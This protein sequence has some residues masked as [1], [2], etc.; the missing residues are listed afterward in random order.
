MNALWMLTNGTPVLV[1]VFAS[2]VL[3]QLQYHLSMPLSLSRRQRRFSRPAVN[4]AGKE[5]RQTARF[6]Q[7]G[8]GFPHG[9]L[10]V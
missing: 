2:G 9:R 4:L 1:G 8:Q 10:S 5:S 6:R 7:I 3:Q